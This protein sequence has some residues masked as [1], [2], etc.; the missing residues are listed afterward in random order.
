[1]FYEYYEKE[2]QLWKFCWKYLLKILFIKGCLYFPAPGILRG[3]QFVF[4]G[5]GP[6][7]VFT[8]PGPQFVFTGP[9]LQFVFTGSGPKFVF[10]VPGLQFYYQSRTWVLHIPTL[11]PQYVFVFTALAYDIYYR[12]RAWICIYLIIGSSSSGSCNNS[13]SNFFGIDNTDICMSI[14]VN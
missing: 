6:V 13:S 7:F 1:M 4:T 8:G 11:S 14:L 3:P 2:W 10:T 5:S 12:S 9:G